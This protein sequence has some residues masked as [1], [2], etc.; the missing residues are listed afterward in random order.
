MANL[1]SEEWDTGYE[2]KAVTLLSL[3]TGL[4]GID[5]YMILALFPLIMVDLQLGYQELGLIIGCLG[6]AY[7]LTAILIGPLSDRVGR[8]VT[9]VAS[10]LVFSLLVGI[11]GLATGL[12]S[13]C[14]MRI[15]MGIADGAF[16]TPAIVA[17]MEASKPSR[18]G[19]NIG[20]MLAM[21]PLC[22]LALAPIF[23]TQLLHFVD[24]R[25]VFFCITPFG[26]IVT[27]LLHRVLRA[28]SESVLAQ[29]TATHD[30]SRHSWRELF[31]YRNVNVCMITMFL[32]LT[33]LIV[34]SSFLPNYL[35]HQ[36]NLSVPEMGFVLSAIGF[37][38]TLGNPLML[39]LSDRIGRKPVALMASAGATIAIT[40]LMMSPPQTA[41]LFSSL[42]VANFFIFPL[43][44]LSIGPTSTE[45]VPAT[46][47]ASAT[48]LITCFGELLGGGLAPVLGGY[49]AAHFGIGSIF[50]LAIGATALG[51][52][53]CCF[54]RETA[55][56]IISRRAV[57]GQTAGS[58]T[59][60]MQS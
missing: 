42:L 39:S 35:V 3:G 13:L 19:R 25:W 47:M 30:A 16:M 52:I 57:V 58:G 7:G 1:K 6:Y 14:I 53:A 37:G 50:Y 38:G 20:I 44:A 49:A 22:G 36:L 27:Y 18:Q 46:L 40:A 15:I 31:R 33:A 54:V 32:W 2:W 60:T 48:G 5:R 8:R 51:C 56:R 4:V 34:L 23:A 12:I 10:V 24:W 21:M 26:L 41:L 9:V 17:T 11:S 29:H 28:P 45:A 43:I 59:L 55:P